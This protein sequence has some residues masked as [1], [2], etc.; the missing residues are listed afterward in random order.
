MAGGLSVEFSQ[1]IQLHDEEEK[2]PLDKD[3]TFEELKNFQRS[4]KLHI[5]S[6]EERSSGEATMDI[7]TANN[8]STVQNVPFDG[9]AGE[10]HKDDLDPPTEDIFQPPPP[11]PVNNNVKRR[12]KKKKRASD[13]L[14]GGFHDIYKLT[15]EI[16]GQGANTTVQGCINTLNNKEYAVKIVHKSARV[17]R[18]RVLNEIELLYHCKGHKNIMECIEYFEDKDKFYMIFEKMEGGPLLK[19]IEK[20]KV[21]TE[22][23]ASMVVRDIA[24][25]L[26]FLHKKGIAHRDLKPDNILCAFANQVSPVKICDFDLASGIDGLSTV[27]TPQ[28]QTPVGSAEYMAPEVVDAFKT[29]ATTYDKKCDLWSLGVILYIMLSGHPPFYGKCGSDCGWERGDSCKACQ[30]ML[31]QRIQESVYEFPEKEWDG[32]SSLAKDLISHLL[33]RDATKRYTADMVLEHPWIDTA[34]HFVLATPTLLSR[35]SSTP[36]N[37]QEFAA[38]AVAVNRM[39]SEANAM[40]GNGGQPRIN[41]LGLSPPSKSGLAKRRAKLHEEQLSHQVFENK[42]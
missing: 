5:P 20:R 7:K 15:D 21:F 34:S 1:R 27:T 8:S 30:E 10:D 35:Q 42:K 16:L 38:E 26:D 4:F 11:P 40:S 12:K 3:T 22:K 41:I 19:H 6:A 28:L 36:D 31:L 24:C 25:A 39:V 18:K 17:D 23:E 29:M 37:L 9:Q 2:K 32:V 14:C 33:V 13:S